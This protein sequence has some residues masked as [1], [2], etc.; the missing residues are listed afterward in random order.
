M[1]ETIEA[2]VAR[3]E[4]GFQNLN[5]V[6]EKLDKILDKLDAVTRLE[7]Q[8]QTHSNGLERAFLAIKENKTD[9]TEAQNKLNERIDRVAESVDDLHLLVDGKLQWAKGAWF[10]ASV[11]WVLIQMA[12]VASIS[13]TYSSLLDSEN[14]LNDVSKSIALFEQRLGR[15]EK[16]GGVGK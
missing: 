14:R 8:Q 11:L 3:L 1:S 10:T 13:M 6:E 16:L 2:R 4:A 12:V 7:Q 15:I 9:A 5:R